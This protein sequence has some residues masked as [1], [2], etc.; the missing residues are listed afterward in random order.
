MRKLHNLIARFLIL[1]LASNV[2]VSIAIEV[3]VSHVSKTSES[4]LC[5]LSHKA[6]SKGA[7]CALVA[8][9][10]A[11]MRPLVAPLQHLK[12]RIKRT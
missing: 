4:K 7:F 1:R 8:T 11:E 9:R 5:A 3:A 2:F 10:H 12:L 6:P